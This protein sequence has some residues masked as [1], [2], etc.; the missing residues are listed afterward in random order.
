MKT[1]PHVEQTINSLSKSLGYKFL[2]GLRQ[3][4]SAMESEGHIQNNGSGWLL[5]LPNVYWSDTSRFH[6]EGK[7]HPCVK[8]GALCVEAIKAY[9][10]KAEAGRLADRG[11]VRI[12]KSEV[13]LA[14]SEPGGAF[15]C[16]NCRGS[17]AIE[18]AFFQQKLGGGVDFWKG[19]ECKEC[20]AKGWAPC[21]KCPDAKGVDFLEE[22]GWEERK[23]P[24]LRIAAGHCG[25]LDDEPKDIEVAELGGGW[26]NLFKKLAG[27]E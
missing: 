16:G 13:V 2:A 14:L 5:V 6:H 19:A 11:V 23:K 26:K 12:E 15:I 7:Q 22:M 3:V 1:E 17:G 18:P 4:T 20:G 9:E 8:C 24:L 21:T 25:C 27:A 10:G